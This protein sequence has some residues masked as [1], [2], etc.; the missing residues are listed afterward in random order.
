MIALCRPEQQWTCAELHLADFTVLGRRRAAVH[1]TSRAAVNSYLEVVPQL[2]RGLEATPMLVAMAQLAVYPVGNYT[3]GS[4]PPKFEKDSSVATRMDRL[5]DKYSREGLRRSVD[6]VLVVHEHGHPHLLVLQMGAS[7]FKLPGGRLR[8]GEDETEGLLRKMTGLLAPPADTMRPDWRVADLLGCWWRPNFE[9]M[10]YPYCPPHIA[11]PK[12][13]RRI[14][15]VAL[16][17]RCYLSVPKN[18]RLVAVPLFEVYDNIAR[19]GPVISA[20]PALLSRFNL[21]LVGR[22]VPSPV[23]GLAA[24]QAV[25]QQAV[26]QQQQQQQ[27][28]VQYGQQQPT[29]AGAGQQAPLQPQKAG[30]TVSLSGVAAPQPPQ[31]QQ[32]QPMQ[33]H[34]QQ[35]DDLLPFNPSRILM[36]A[37]TMLA[38]SLLRAACSTGGAGSSSVEAIAQR[39]LPAASSRCTWLR[40]YS[41]ESG[42]EKREISDPT[43]LAL[44][45]QIITLNLLQVADLTEI[46]KQRLGIQAPMMGMPM[47]MMGGGMPAA[48]GGAAAEAPAEAAPVEEKTEF[49][50]KLE[51]YE[52]ASK[53]KVIKEV[54]AMT[55][56]GL[57]E[58]KE[59]VEGAPKVVKEGLKKEEAEALQ[60]TLV[61]D[62]QPLVLP[63]IDDCSYRLITLNNG[64]RAL[65]VHDPQAEKGAASCDVRVGSLSDPDDVAG[66][67]HFTEHM[68]FYSSEKYPEEDEYSKYV[69]EHGGHTNAYTSNES[70]NYHFDVNW[71][72]LEPALDRFAQF[73]IAPLISA[74][75]V[76]REAKAVDSEHG[77][78]LNSDP[79][80]KLQLWKATAN[81]AH[82]FSRFSTGSYDTLITQPKAVGVDPHERVR[83][84]HQQ[85]Y[86]AGVMRLAVV[87]RHSLD[88]LEAL[89]R[90]KF[91]AVPN[92]GISA[93]RFPPEATTQ[94]Q[95]GLLIRMVPE[96]EGHSIELQWP[97]VSEH[98]RYRTIPSSY[99][100]HLLGSRTFFMCRIDLTDEGQAHVGEAVGVIFRYLDLLRQPGGVNERLWRE[101]RQLA[102]MRF[103]YRDKASPYSYASSLSQ[104]M[105]VFGDADLLLGSYSVPLEYDPDLIAQVVA[106]LTPQAARVLWAS[107]ALEAECGEREKWYGTR[108]STQPL[109]QDWLQE[110]VEGPAL[111][112][113]HLP[114]TNPFI[115]QQFG[116]LKDKAA[117]PAL[118]HS[119]TMVRLWHK[120][121]PSF[122][123]PKAVL[124]INLQLPEAYVTPEAA[125]LT[126]LYTKL[127]NDYL[128]ELAYDAD[129]AGLHYGVRPSTEGLLLTI[130]GYSDTAATLAQTVLDRAL[131]F[132]VLPDRYDQ[133]YQYAL[134]SLGVLLEARRWHVSDYEAVLP[135]LTADRLQAHFPRLFSRCRA[136]LFATGNLSAAAATHFAGQLEK[137]LVGR[138][139]SQPPFPSQLP[140][141]RVVSLPP[142]RPALLSQ[143][144][145]NPANDNLAAVVAFQVGADAPRLNVLA[146]LLTAIGRRDAF[147]QLRT[148]EQLGYLTF[149]TA[150]WTLH[151][152]SVL[153][154]VQSTSHSAA[155]LES[156]IEAFLP[157]LSQRLSSMSGEEFSAHVEELAKSKLEKPKRLREAA[158]RDWSELDGGTLMFD[159]VEQEVA[160]LRALSLADLAAFYQEAVLE[161]GSRRKLSV[162]IEA[163]RPAAA[164][165]DK[166]EGSQAAAGGGGDLTGA[167]AGMEDSQQAGLKDDKAAAA[168]GS[169]AASVEGAGQDSQE[170]PA[171]PQHVAAKEGAKP[172]PAAAAGS[173]SGSLPCGEGPAAAAAGPTKCGVQVERI[174]DMW[175]WKRRQQLYGGFK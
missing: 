101:M 18:M 129:L 111:P 134:Y 24:A 165:G 128:S 82:P 96:R 37:H 87:S 44:A 97:T 67:A 174:G 65:V 50:L 155:Y 46:L 105:Q 168:A 43:V 136:E 137:A 6:A 99:V 41:S 25:A 107:K 28:L 69:S 68:L 14:F 102:D 106:D 170:V 26:A 145:P 119:S 55:G 131:S 130:Y 7:F 156:R 124:Y 61:D 16:P 80:R 90:D 57:K 104:A 133:P 60:K 115:P 5:K 31:Q 100:S 19:Y 23:A 45:D 146:E 39:L 15:L 175:E 143:P 142:G 108:Y 66:L 30:I 10:M 29:A 120:P 157:M 127:L 77:K 64:L 35:D 88:E 84:F 161:P 33:T 151:V 162:H 54:R 3:F 126:Q 73:F 153:F 11:R 148:V 1:G 172:E 12:E 117:V 22:A 152:R 9:N 86:S 139:Q 93:P 42:E 95:G 40:H 63:S 140:D 49:S 103:N 56:L 92:G 62:D 17:E 160:A 114:H 125:V 72:A 58:A 8:P 4:K 159:R 110:W 71:D 164:D 70:T 163:S 147:H 138:C 83:L 116:L 76:E 135:A 171:P 89:V 52:A 13:Q 34:Y 74:D 32:A 167:I 109:P 98:E 113:L 48:G 94:E 173:G 59:L 78:N 81:P 85:H 36:G 47:H 154:I 53:I 123:V 91:S 121:D 112:E 118:I 150:Y 166:D 2:A 132:T 158:G 79:W 38:R 141:A 122:R 149:F 20:I 75:G 51:G 169:N 144:G 27:Q 21:S